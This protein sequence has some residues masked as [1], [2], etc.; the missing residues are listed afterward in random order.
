Q[1]TSLRFVLHMT[2]TVSPSTIIHAAPAAANAKENVMKRTEIISGAKSIF[3][4]SSDGITFS[5]NVPKNAINNSA[6]NMYRSSMSSATFRTTDDFSEVTKSAA[7]M[8]TST[9]TPSHSTVIYTTLGALVLPSDNSSIKPTMLFPISVILTSP[10]VK[11][12]SPTPN[13]NP[14]QQTTKLN[15]NSSKPVTASPN[16]KDANEVKTKKEVIVGIIVGAILGSVLI[17]SIG[18]FIYAVKR[19][20]SFSHRWLQGV[21]QVRNSTNNS[22]ELYDMSFRCALDDKTSTADKTEEDNAGC[23]SDSI[24]M[25]D[26]T[27][28]HPSL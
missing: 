14:I 1:L 24:P 8:S 19:P 21:T 16:P 25:A 20:E 4:K 15:N 2:T 18:Y 3:L 12:D 7:A 28:S 26:I 9:W 5:S 17:G 10:I 6:I 23:P 11:Q 13:F 27:P 22:S